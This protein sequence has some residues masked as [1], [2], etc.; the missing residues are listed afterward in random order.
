MQLNIGFEINVSHIGHYNIIYCTFV[1]QYVSISISYE[2]TPFG[3]VS[4][5][6][7]TVVTVQV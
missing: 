5:I 1:L 2:I 4:E 6:I 3:M 7:V